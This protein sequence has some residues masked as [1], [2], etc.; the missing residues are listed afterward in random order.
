MNKLPSWEQCKRNVDN[1][2]A[3]ALETFIYE[4]EPAGSK[5]E[6]MFRNGLAAALELTLSSSDEK[7]KDLRY[8]KELEATEEAANRRAMPRSSRMEHGSVP[9]IHSVSNEKS[10][11]E[12][13][14]ALRSI[15]R[16]EETIHGFEPTTEIRIPMRLLLRLVHGKG[17]IS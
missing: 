16:R 11:A 7:A 15:A 5:D 14:T 3:T 9:D 13:A 10:L 17:S 1:G 12:V 8:K 6:G 4:N 2:S